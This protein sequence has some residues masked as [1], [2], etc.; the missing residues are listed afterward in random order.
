MRSLELFSGSGGLAE[1]LRL[2]G[3]EHEALIEW[4]KDACNS[5]RKNFDKVPVYETDIRNVDFT[6]RYPFEA[7]TAW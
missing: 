6:Q 7:R 1:G 3:F 4:N 5:L 2:S